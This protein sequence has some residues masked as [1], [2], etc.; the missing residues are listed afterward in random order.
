YARN[1]VHLV[2]AIFQIEHLLKPKRLCDALR[3]TLVV[4]NALPRRSRP[5]HFIVGCPDQIAGVPFTD[6]FRDRPSRKN[7]NIVGVR[8]NRRQHLSR[9]R[10]ARSRA[11]DKNVCADRRISRLSWMTR[12]LRTQLPARAHQRSANQEITKKVSTSH[13]TLQGR[14]RLLLHIE[15][16]PKSRTPVLQSPLRPVKRAVEYSGNPK[17][18]ISNH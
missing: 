17:S 4:P 3:I 12:L 5:G 9:V 13:T 16:P 11:F 1:V 7:R 8:L 15:L 18:A 10:F 2:I 14:S 6:Q